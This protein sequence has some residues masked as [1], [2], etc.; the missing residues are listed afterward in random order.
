[1]NI[2]LKKPT[3]PNKCAVAT[4]HAKEHDPVEDTVETVGTDPAVVP[5]TAAPV[6]A[7]PAFEQL[8]TPNQ[9]AQMLNVSPAFLAKD[10]NLARR[11]NR[12]PRIP[13]V[14]IGAA[15]RYRFKVLVGMIEAGG[16]AGLKPNAD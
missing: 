10:R 13:Y 15:V 3:A 12:E 2:K 14:R 8:F 16:T 6:E 5:V 7:D 11:Y 1:M 4:L 9:T